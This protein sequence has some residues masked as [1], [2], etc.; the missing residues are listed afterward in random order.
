M[1]SKTGNIAT[2]IL[3]PCPQ[4]EKP[5]MLQSVP[6]LAT[7]HAIVGALAATQFN[8]PAVSLVVAFI[9]HPLLDLFP[10]WDFNSRWT[11]RSKIRT[12][13]LSAIDS[14]SGM[15]LGLILFATKENFLF[16]IL[17]MLVAQWAD[18]LEAPYHFGW[19]QV[20]FF[21]FIKHLQHLWHTKAPW[22]WGMYPQLAILAAALWIRFSP[23]L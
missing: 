13:I 11:K 6:M 23:L 4:P 20:P 21:K 3:P 5:A 16:L 7:T 2:D 9:S 17:T 22:P 1:D 8:H 12:F 14:G 15:L 19:D 18:F 10:H